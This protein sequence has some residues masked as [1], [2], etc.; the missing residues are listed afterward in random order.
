MFAGGGTVIGIRAGCFPTLG[1]FFDWDDFIL[2]YEKKKY[3][4]CLLSVVSP[5]FLTKALEL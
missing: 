5:T 4:G 2:Y 3:W 1:I